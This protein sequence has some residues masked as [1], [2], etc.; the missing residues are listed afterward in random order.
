MERTA[1]DEAIILKKGIN[2]DNLAFEY[3]SDRILDNYEENGGK[4]FTGITYEL[5]DNGRISYYCYYVNGFSEGDFVKFYKDGTIRSIS[6][7]KRG[8]CTE[9]TE[10]Y[11]DG[12]IKEKGIYNCGICLSNEKWDE[13]G[14]L[15][16][17][18]VSPTESE[19]L[20]IKKLSSVN[21]E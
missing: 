7:M 4:P 16:Y 5:Y 9:K 19:M 1:I 13:Q 21:Y 8:K 6:K 10:W 14:N 11:Q 18:K 12:K 15:V 2:F 20:L 3:C 17:E